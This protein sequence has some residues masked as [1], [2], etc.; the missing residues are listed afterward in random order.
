M[1]TSR[2]LPRSRRLLR[3]GGAVQLLDCHSGA[4]ALESSL[5]LPRSLLVDLLEHRL[6]G[7]FH[8]VLR[9]LE[10]EAC[11]TAHLFDDLDLLLAHAIEDD[12]ELVL[13]FLGLDRC[14]RR[15][16]TRRGRDGNRGCGGDTKGVLELLD[17]LG[18]LEERHLLER[19]K[20]V[21]GAELRHDRRFLPY[22]PA[23]VP[24][25]RSALV[26]WSG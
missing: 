12:V 26:K 9:L 1:A 15:G 13:L 18:E 23:M 17:E 4:G 21:V 3:R 16:G 6:R 14:A 2:G 24:D 19:V 7:A 22:R 8:Q 11:Q 10:A 5:G 25:V 20:Q